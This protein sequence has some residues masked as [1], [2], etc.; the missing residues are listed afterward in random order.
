MVPIPR[1][2]AS[3]APRQIG[4][5]APGLGWH[6][7]VPIVSIYGRS[8]V[9]SRASTFFLAAESADPVALDPNREVRLHG[10]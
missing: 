7:Y 4:C 1:F 3:R 2:D 5:Q 8:R 9:V 10:P 6:F